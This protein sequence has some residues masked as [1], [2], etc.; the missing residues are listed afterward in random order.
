MDFPILLRKRVEMAV[1]A[2][3]GHGLAARTG[4]SLGV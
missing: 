2:T 1:H 4:A 3:A